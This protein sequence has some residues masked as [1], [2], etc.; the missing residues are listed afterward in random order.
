M[1]TELVPPTADT[2]VGAA[3]TAGPD[4][5]IVIG[6]LTLADDTPSFTVI[7]AVK[8]PE[9]VGVPVITPPAEIDSPAGS[10]VADQVNVPVPPVAFIVVEGYATLIVP[11]GSDVV[12]ILRGG[13]VMERDR[14]A[15][16]AGVDESVTDTVNVNVPVAVGVPDIVP[17]LATEIPGGGVPTVTDHVYGAVPFEALRLV[18]V[19]A[20]LSV[21]FAS[22][23]V[24]TANPG[25]ED[26]PPPH[27]ATATANI[28]KNNPVRHDFIVLIR[29]SFL[30]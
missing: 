14:E 22:V 23:A 13:T 3:G 18:G 20:L 9:T 7:E 6:R 25:G 8:G 19:Y 17:S 21:P 12:V 24:L 26:V 1:V 10:P 15:V 16:L 11:A 4:V 28:I 5:F 27:P 29:I 2:P 30:G